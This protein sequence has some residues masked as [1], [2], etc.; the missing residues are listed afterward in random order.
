MMADFHFLRPWWLLAIL[1]AAALFLLLIRNKYRGGNWTQ[2]CDA[3]LLPY[4][5]QEKPVQ[6][7][8]GKWISACLATLLGILALAGPTWNRLPSPAFRND[9]ALVVALDLSKSMDATDVK[10]SRVVR[11]RYKIADILKRRKDGQTALLVYS[12]DAFTVTPL[13][14]DTETINSQLEALDTDIMPSQGSNAGV[15]IAKAADLLRQAGLAHG[16][17][18]LVSDGTDA[19]SVADAR[20]E[21]GDYRLSVLAIGTEDGAPIPMPGGGFL[22]DEHGNIVVAK[23][24]S[25]ELAELASIGH[26][27][28]QAI[29]ANDNDID[30]L[31]EAINDAANQDKVEQIDLRLQQWDEKGPWLMLAVLPWAALQ[32]RRG[33]LALALAVMLPVPNDAWAFDW[34]G[35]WQTRDQQGHQAF[36]DQQYQ[37]AADRFDDPSWRAAAQYK[38]GQ[39]QQAADTLKDTQTA[40]GHYNRGNALAKAG[41]L[42]EAVKEYQAALKL[43]PKHSDAEYN[44]ELVEKQLQDQQ[45]SKSQQSSGKADESQNQQNKDQESSEQTGDKQQKQEQQSKQADQKDQQGQNQAQSQQGQ[46][47]ESSESDNQQPQQSQSKQPEPEQQS[48]RPDEARR[49]SGNP[50][51]EQAAQ[52]PQSEVDTEQE[53]AERA[54][55]QL[56]KRIPDEPTGLLKRKFK[57]QYGQRDPPPH[58]GPDW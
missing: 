8:P 48:D 39:Y 55:E 26:G 38:A 50:K 58:T 49:S 1:P 37:E 46:D 7:S 16:H 57:Y 35:L 10:P 4:I 43:D 20:K 27:R 28:Y 31:S 32:F 56:L 42:Q 52:S 22:K 44:K 47:K 18:L 17:V 23:L 9:S 41:Q 53:E 2:V 6:S 11:A 21:L 19:E 40:D 3:E 29:T 13:T 54:N 30:Q 34:Q 33:L 12:G 5:L 51:P 45:K 36:S 24:D 25:E 14:T 15:A